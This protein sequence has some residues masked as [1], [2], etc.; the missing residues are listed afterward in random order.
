MPGGDKN[1]DREDLF[2]LMESYRNMIQMNATLAEQQKQIMELQNRIIDNQ[3]KIVAGALCS[4]GEIHEIK[5]DL[6]EC[7]TILTTKIND[8]ISSASSKSDKNF[9]DT[10]TTLTG[11]KIDH[12][13]GVSGLSNK[14]Y[15]AMIGSLTIIISLIGLY[16]NTIEKN[17]ML[18]EI[19]DIVLKLVQP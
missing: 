17:K 19:Y 16:V 4:S 8:N 11:L 9:E 6:E 12:T 15:I 7:R 3:E 18:K 5:T 10:K 13:K 2:L 1:L 14:I